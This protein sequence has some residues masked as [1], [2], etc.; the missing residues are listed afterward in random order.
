MVLPGE[1]APHF[2]CEAVMA[3]GSFGKIDLSSYKGKYVVLFFWP[4]D[5]TFVC[6]TEIL[7]Y[8]KL[9]AELKEKNAVILGCSCDSK[10]VHA[11][12][13]NTEVKN[14]G[15]GKVDF[16]LL[17]DHRGQIVDAFGC[18]DKVEGVPL[19]ATYIINPDQIVRH[20]E[21][22]DLSI[23]RNTSSVVRIIEADMHVAKYGEV[24]PANWNKSKKSMKPTK[25]GVQDYLAT[26]L[27]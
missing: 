24:C 1:Q 8:N 6:P 22:S 23:G 7:E 27:A 18:R 5:F 25:E 26:H 16:P 21:I 20:V 19:R 13:R 3:D 9:H 4:Y 14:G 15:I 12:W 10:F 11:A 17:D 2:T